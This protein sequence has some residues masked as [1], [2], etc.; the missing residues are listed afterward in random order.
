MILVRLRKSF[1]KRRISE[2]LVHFDSDWKADKLLLKDPPQKE[3]YIQPN[4]FCFEENQ[5]M[6]YG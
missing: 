2:R 5:C 1:N 4:N 6:A 3:T